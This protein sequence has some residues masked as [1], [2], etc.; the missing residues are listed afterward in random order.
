MGR[1]ER[2]IPDFVFDNLD[3]LKSQRVNAG[4]T[5][6]SLAALI[7]SQESIITNYENSNMMPGRNKRGHERKMTKNR[8][9][10]ENARPAH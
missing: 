3:N 4:F 9:S 6:K 2:Y 8:N 1:Q 10:T 7:G 5:Q